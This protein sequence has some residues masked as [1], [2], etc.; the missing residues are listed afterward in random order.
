M[1]HHGYEYHHQPRQDD[2]IGKCC[3]ELFL[4]DPEMDRAS[5][6][7][8]KGD[9]VSGTCEWIRRDDKYN[10]WRTGDERLLWVSGGPGKGKTILSIFLTQDLEKEERNTQVSSQY[11]YLSTVPSMS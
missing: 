2:K 6:V 1:H 4:T 11:H 9:R 8:V 3:N 7:S 10:C 5:L